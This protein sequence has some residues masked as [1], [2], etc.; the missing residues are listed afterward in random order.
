MFQ[1]AHAVCRLLLTSDRIGPALVL[2]YKHLLPAMTLLMG[3]GKGISSGRSSSTAQLSRRLLLPPPYCVPPAGS[4][5]GHG[6]PVGS[7]S[8]CAVCGAAFNSAL[9][10]MIQQ[11]QQQLHQSH[12][13]QEAVCGRI[14]EPAI[15]AAPPFGGELP[16]VHPRA[17]GTA[18]KPRRSVPHP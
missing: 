15:A 4:F 13:P 8:C 12:H 11:E 17:I 3:S 10:T 16:A 2:H 6:L 18:I 1:H 14:V 5:S 9:Q 7:P